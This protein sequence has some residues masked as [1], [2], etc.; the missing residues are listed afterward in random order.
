M[1]Y[2]QHKKYLEESWDYFLNEI[3]ADIFFFQ[4][5][6]RPKRI[7]NDK[8]FLWHN[9]G[10]SNGRKEWGSGI[11]CTRYKLSEE[12]EESILD[13]NRDRFKEFCVIANAKI[14]ED[15][16]LTL[17]SLYG[18]MDKIGNKR[19]KDASSNL[20]KIFSDLTGILNRHYGKRNI[21]LGGD[22]NISIQFD[23][24]W[25]GDSGKILLNRLKDYNLENCYELNGNEDFVQTLRF[26]KSG[27]KWQND[28]FFISKSISR[29]FTNCEVV[30]NN[31]VRKYSDHNPVVIT[32]DL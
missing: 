14:T 30:D 21:I 5:A 10:E 2:W 17:I 25:G 19:V 8:N 24:K 6:K 20:H 18:R 29:K 23:K 12:P 27:T 16:S 13:W 22:F 28:Y 1:S 26:P 7:E 11:Y 4:E 3:N 9:T 15:I 32:L 31:L